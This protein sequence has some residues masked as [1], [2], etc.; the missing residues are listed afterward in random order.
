MAAAGLRGK[1]RARQQLLQVMLMSWGFIQSNRRYRQRRSREGAGSGLQF[2]QMRYHCTPIGTPKTKNINNSA[3]QQGCR[4][5][6]ILIHCWQKFKMVE[7]LWKI[8]LADSYKVKH[9]LTT[10]IPLIYLPKKMRTCFYSQICT[11]VFRADLFVVTQARHNP[12]VLK[13]ANG[14]ANCNT[15]THTIEY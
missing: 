9:A 12:N 2:I 14:K 5:T 4:A 15:S 6:G 7:P 3:C 11:L 10:E 13:L 1:Q 8:N